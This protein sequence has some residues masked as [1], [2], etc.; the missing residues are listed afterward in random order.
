MMELRPELTPPALDESLVARL[1]ELVSAIDG[2]PPGAWEDHL[3][4]FNRLAGTSI[5]FEELQGIYGAEEY[6]DYVRRVLYGRRVAPDPAITKTELT[7]IVSRVLS[8][9]EHRDFYMELFEV[10]CKHPSGSDLIYWPDLV[11]EL[12]QD[13]EPT[14]EEIAELAMRGPA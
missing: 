3:A 9:G 7:E 2:A 1:A 8:G 14:A 6:A 10:N 5:P 11:P 13:R 4:E 12:P